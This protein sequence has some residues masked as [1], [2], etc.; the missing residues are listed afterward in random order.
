MWKYIKNIVVFTFI[1]TLISLNYNA[2]VEIKFKNEYGSSTATAD[3]E[4]IGTVSLY[5]SKIAYPKPSRLTGH[6]WIY[7]YNT[8]DSPFYI[9]DMIVPPDYGISFG[10]T[11]NP[12]MGHRGLWYNVE[13]F[14]K[15]YLTNISI[16]GDFYEEDIEYVEAFL[17]NHNKWT[18]FYNCTT[19]ATELWNNLAAGKDREIKAI[20]PV[21]LHN[22]ILR[23]DDY[24]VNKPFVIF[25]YMKAMK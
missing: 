12:S 6:S 22:D 23:T 16:E 8:T 1:I 21:T 11:A 3:S 17:D 14:S 25:D 13:G 18:L 2:I 15:Y 4:K 10:T 19:F 9:K 5:S 20:T 24:Y 7:I